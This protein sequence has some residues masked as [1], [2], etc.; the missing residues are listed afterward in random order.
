MSSHKNSIHPIKKIHETPKENNISLHKVTDQS[1]DTKDII[2]NL[3]IPPSNNYHQFCKTKSNKYLINLGPQWIIHV[4]ITVV[5]LS[6]G[7]AVLFVNWGNADLLLKI[8]FI[9]MLNLFTLF[10]FIIIIL[11]PG[12]VQFQSLIPEYYQ[13]PLM[14]VNKVTSYITNSSCENITIIQNDFRQKIAI[15]KLDIENIGK[16]KKPSIFRAEIGSN[17][18]PTERPRLNFI[19]NNKLKEKAGD[20]LDLKKEKII[21]GACLSRAKDRARHCKQCNVCIKGWDHHCVF[22]GK[23]VGKNNIYFFYAYCVIVPCYIINLL[24][25]LTHWNKKT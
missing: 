2:N 15:P 24:V 5:L 25:F 16:K 19:L 8:V 23:C 7:L 11:D 18:K 17:S 14:S 6:G 13:N 4:I 3:I 21:C 22:I 12:I 10:S 9:L 1:L 20:F